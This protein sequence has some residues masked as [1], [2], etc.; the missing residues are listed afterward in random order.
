MF[1]VRV[2]SPQIQSFMTMYIHV[3][4]SD[5]DIAVERAGMSEGIDQAKEP[6]MLNSGGGLN[7]KL[8]VY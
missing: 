7:E 2:V 4:A 1:L 5:V 3:K 6:N 8:G